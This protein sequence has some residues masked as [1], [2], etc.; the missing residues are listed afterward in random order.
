MNS[1]VCCFLKERGFAADL[2]VSNQRDD[3]ERISVS[4]VS[5]QAQKEDNSVLYTLIEGQLPHHKM[6]CT[7]SPY[8]HP[9]PRRH[10]GRKL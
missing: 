7:I 10:A 9:Q 3:R 2:T 8:S 6:Q 1:L 5:G 4:N